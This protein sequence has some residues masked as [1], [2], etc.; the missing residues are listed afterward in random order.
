MMFARLKY[1]CY[2]SFIIKQTSAI[3]SEGT[4]DLVECDGRLKSYAM[5]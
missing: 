2:L 5:L 3:P 4:E 1:L